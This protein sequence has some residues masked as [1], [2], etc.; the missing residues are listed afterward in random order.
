MVSLWFGKQ[1][2]KK[3]IPLLQESQ[4]IPGISLREISPLGPLMG[5]LCD[6][7]NNRCNLRYQLHSEGETGSDR[8]DICLPW[9]LI[10]EKHLSEV[11]HTMKSY[12]CIWFYLLPN[13]SLYMRLYMLSL[14]LTGIL[15]ILCLH[16]STL[17]REQNTPPMSQWSHTTSKKFKFICKG[18][19]V[20]I[21]VIVSYM[22]FPPCTSMTLTRFWFFLL[23]LSISFSLSIPQH[24]L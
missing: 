18:V 10:Q 15:C 2:K 4:V 23:S 16:L 11:K 24:H 5:V 7:V 3:A 12:T 1:K 13:K 20:F 19:Y 14:Y 8:K 6:G 9:N 21:Y 17:K 22:E